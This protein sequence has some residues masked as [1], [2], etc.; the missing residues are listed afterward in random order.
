MKKIKILQFAF[1]QAILVG[2]L[3]LVCGIFYSFGG[4]IYDLSIS[5][6][7]NQ[8]TALAFNALIGMPFIGVTVGFFTGIV[9]A[10]LYNLLLSFVKIPPIVFFE[11]N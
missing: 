3:G 11:E 8:G 1:F 10:I 5:G 6:S 7:F 4:A 2:L 9:E